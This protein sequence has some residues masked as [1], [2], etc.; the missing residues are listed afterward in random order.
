MLS[1]SDFRLS[2][3]SSHRYV[4]LEYLIIAALYDFVFAVFFVSFGFHYDWLDLPGP[5]LRILGPSRLG[6]HPLEEVAQVQ[7]DLARHNK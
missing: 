6:I 2:P 3:S 1:T 4:L 5:G 7:Q